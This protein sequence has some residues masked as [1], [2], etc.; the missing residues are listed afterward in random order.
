MPWIPWLSACTTPLHA[1]HPIKN[2]EKGIRVVDPTDTNLMKI[3][4]DAIMTGKSVLIENLG[5]EIDRHRGHD[6]AA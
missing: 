3:I 4:E 2:L 5:E 6:P 1:N